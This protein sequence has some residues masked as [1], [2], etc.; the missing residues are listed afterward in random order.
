MS[1]TPTPKTRVLIVDDHRTFAEAVS[2]VVTMQH[3]MSG[4]AVTSGTEAERSVT[5]D[6]P[7]VVLLGAVPADHE[8]GSI[9]RLLEL[10][11]GVGVLIV[12]DDDDDQVRA[13]ASRAGAHG[14]LTTFEP[15]QQILEAIRTVSS[16]ERMDVRTP[17]DGSRGASSGKRRRQPH[18]SERQRADRLSPREREILQLMADGSE[19]AQIV[20]QLG[21]TP[22][23]LRTHVQNILTKL[24]V[25]SKT[26][27]VLMA[28]RQGKVTGR[29]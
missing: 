2:A 27:A 19:P 22:A 26:Q 6:P 7:D 23:T 4:R 16:G 11:P 24:R 20:E 5:D 21:I 28:I 25:H 15:I 10:A 17:E 14:F 29:R 12:T 18:A 1:T 13:R 3:D 8:P 9:G